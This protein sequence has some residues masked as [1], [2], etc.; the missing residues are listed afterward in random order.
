MTPSRTIQGWENQRVQP[1]PIHHSD[2]NPFEYRIT[3]I[4]L[5]RGYS[6]YNLPTWHHFD[7]VIYLG[8]VM[9][10]LVTTYLVAGIN[11]KSQTILKCERI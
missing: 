11:G 9:V 1:M 2:F 10:G 4:R 7:R 6:R 5:K 3:E 8:S